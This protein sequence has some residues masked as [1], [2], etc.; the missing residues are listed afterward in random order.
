MFSAATGDPLSPHPKAT[1]LH[2]LAHE[3]DDV[4][5]FEAKLQFDR[6]KGGAIFPGHLNNAIAIACVQFAQFRQSFS[7][8]GSGSVNISAEVFISYTSSQ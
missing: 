7:H 1:R 2:G 5:F 4:F 3:P 8:R 6:L